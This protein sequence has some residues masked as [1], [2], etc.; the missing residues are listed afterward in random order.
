MYVRGTGN[1]VLCFSRSD[2][3]KF[4]MRTDVGHGEIVGLHGDSNGRS[5]ESHRVCGAHVQPGD[6]LRF[7]LVIVDIDNEV[8]EAIACHRIKDGVESCRI[9][10]LSRNLA[11]RSKHQFENKF[12]QVL[13]L[14]EQSEN[15]A[16]RNKSYR[17][18]G[19]ASFRLL[20]F[21]PINE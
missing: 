20:E 11:A 13:E 15:V 1:C 4:S 21:I 16:K 7:K 5:C 9:G 14:Y 18:K 8:Q 3:G 17:N 6:C 10:F 2:P 19:M 12:A